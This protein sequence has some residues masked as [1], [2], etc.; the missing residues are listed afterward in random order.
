[1]KCECLVD[2]SSEWKLYSELGDL[3]LDLPRDLD[4]LVD[5]LCFAADLLFLGSFPD[6]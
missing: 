3:L 6:K 1:M 2:L 5:E 4:H